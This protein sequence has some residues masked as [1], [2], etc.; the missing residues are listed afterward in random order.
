[1]RV[2][3]QRQPLD[4]LLTKKIPL[5][6]LQEA[7][8]ESRPVTACTENLASSWILSPNPPA[9]GESYNDYVPKASP[10]SGYKKNNL[11]DISTLQL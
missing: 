4:V 11:Q 6:I 5:L 8:W 9:S 3:G 2:G 1:M 10:S 7:S